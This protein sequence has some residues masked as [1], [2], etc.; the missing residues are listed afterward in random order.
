MKEPLSINNPFPGLR[1]FEQDENVLFFGREKE[2]DAL[3]NK[4]MSTRFIAV[5]GSPGSG[6]S[7]LIK[8]GLIPKLQSGFMFITNSNW[9]ICDFQPGINPIRNMAI[10]LSETYVLKEDENTTDLSNLFENTLRSNSGGLI[11]ICRQ[12]GRSKNNNL[13]I[14]IDQFE[15][16][17]RFSNV[18]S[19]PKGEKRDSIAF[20]N[21][22]LEAAKQLDY[23]IYIVFTMRSD[24]LSNC[25]EFSGLPEAIN[26]GIFLVPRMTRD[27]KKEAI[28]GPLTLTNTK[29]SKRLLCHL[30]ND[31]DDSPDQLPI[32]QHSLMRTFE[33][34]QEKDKPKEEIDIFDYE[35]IG[36]IDFAI[37]RHADEAF[38]ELS[39]DNERRICEIIFKALTQKETGSKGVRRPCKI[40]DL[41]EIT[42]STLEEV[43]QVINTFR[44]C[45]RAFL[46]PPL[47]YTLEEDT[48]ID[49]SHESIMRIWHKLIIWIEEESESSKAY[50][51]LSEAALLHSEGRAG[52]LRNPELQVSLKWR[53][54][55]QPNEVWA[56]RYNA[57][58]E[59]SIRFLDYS[60]LQFDL[61][62]KVKE[63]K[64]RLRLLRIQRTAIVTSLLL[65]GAIFLSIY[66]W[67][68]KT[69]ADVQTK[70]AKSK[71]LEAR[72]SQKVALEQT[73][74]AILNKEEAL[75]E[76]LFAQI[77]E[78]KALQQKLMADEAKII[79]EKN[80]IEALRQKDEAYKQRMEAIK[81]K[82]IAENQKI[83]AQKQT[84]LAHEN[85]LKAIEEKKLSNRLKDLAY[86][87]ILANDAYIL[88]NEKKV[89]EGEELIKKSFLLNKVNQGP[90]QNIDI[91]NALQVL[92]ENKI[93]SKNQLIIHKSPVRSKVNLPSSNFIY[94]ADESGYIWLSELTEDGFRPIRAIKLSDPLRVL[95]ISPESNKLIALSTNGIGYCLAISKD[96]IITLVNKFEF[97]GQAKSINF[98]SNDEFILHTSLGLDLYQ[99]GDRVNRKRF[100][101]K[102]MISNL[103]ILKNGHIYLSI[104]N[105]IS[106]YN[107]YTKLFESPTWKINLSE[108][109]NSVIS[110]LDIEENEKYLALGL[111]DGQIYVKDLRVGGL[112]SSKLLHKST[113][114]SLKFMHLNSG[115]LLLITTSFD[116]SLKLIDVPTYLIKKSIVNDSD[117]I[118]DIISIKNHNKWIYGVDLI[119]NDWII[120]NGEDNKLIAFKPT[121]E[122]LYLS[123]LKK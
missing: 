120:T 18:E 16:I 77:S 40:Q 46:T 100:F 24:F 51:R 4:L 48:I 34:W 116:H 25:T 9:R 58:F 49:I 99:I 33:F 83:I 30:L 89:D 84:I 70:L 91:F 38:S 123:I 122:D 88:L 86:S 79:A 2:I 55:Q 75:N 69:E 47:D 74:R 102:A 76:K 113:V 110:S 85:E 28:V 73:K 59:K 21:L 6:K 121:M 107:D 3:F 112:S 106:F 22:L 11:E 62:L 81:S 41:V 92:W 7:S 35:G 103:K 19:D 26:E 32:L 14:L 50:L 67:S 108:N 118:E 68:K 111:N 56:S 96:K 12:S 15:E 119:G 5:I 36:T 95:S 71:T 31:L 23:P 45:G 1:A 101:S 66:A 63:E 104:G 43:V 65:I 90:S 115:R 29:I 17:F 114:N 13:L 57:Y 27:E 78:R 93:K 39:T 87:R 8:S 94:S 80:R 82:D 72:A 61:E 109:N 105:D 42:N 117:I 53:E 37:S 98:I 64:Q 20:I 60:K 97:A 10:A 52:V 44:K 54:T